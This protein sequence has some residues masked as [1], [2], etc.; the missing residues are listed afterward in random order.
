MK[1]IDR[2]WFSNMKGT[3]GIVVIEEDN[4]HDRKG[5]I[6]VVEGKDEDLDTE[7]LLSWGLSFSLGT[8]E[9]LAAT[10]TQPFKSD[11]SS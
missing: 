7:D 5:Y 6:G 9:R 10:L 11:A 3:C 4:T 8:A 1:V 2:I